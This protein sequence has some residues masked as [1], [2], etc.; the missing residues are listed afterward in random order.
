MK[1]AGRGVD[2]QVVAIGKA[3][4]ALTLPFD[5]EGAD[6][7]RPAA[8]AAV[9]VAGEDVYA[10]FAAVFAAGGTDAAAGHAGTPH[11][12]GDA[13]AAAVQVARIGVDAARLAE[14]EA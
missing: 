14:R 12:A 7:A 5:A 9:L 2:A 8:P 11:V 6:E 4:H 13:T 10:S 3:A 1:R